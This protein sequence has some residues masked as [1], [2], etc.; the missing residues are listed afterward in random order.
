MQPRL[1]QGRPDPRGT[2]PRGP[3]PT[4]F[5][6]LLLLLGLTACGKPSGE[7]PFSQ[8]MHSGKNYYDQGQITNAIVRFER[9]V[10][11]E[12]AQPDA[13]LNLANAYLL[14][15]QP[16]RALASAEQALSFDRNLAAGY[17]VAGCAHLRLRQFE[18]AVKAFFSA[19]DL[20]ANVAA[21]HYQLGV[22][23]VELGQVE[24][25]AASFEEAIRLEP[26]HPVAHYALGQALIRAGRQ[27]E[28]LEAIQRHQ[29]IRAKNPNAPP[30]TT[31]THERCVYTQARAPQKPARPDPKG[32][33][34][35]FTEAT[36][37]VFGDTAA[38]YRAP[39]A[40]LDF[41]RND[42]NGLFVA[43]GTH[44]FR[45]LA[46]RDGRFTPQGEP[47]ARQADTAF[48]AALTGDLNNDRYEDVLVLGDTA[49]HAFRFAT[50]GAARDLTRA[51]GLTGLVARAGAF[52]DLDFT[53]KLDLIALRPDG[54]G[55]RVLRNLGSM[56]FIDITATSG[57]PAQ[58]TGA[59]QLAVD[60][61]N[62]DDLL[63]VF[64]SRTGAPPLYL[65]K[66]RGGPLVPTNLPAGTLEGS[67]LA[68][69]DVNG[70]SRTDLFVGADTHVDLLLGGIDRF[71][72]LPLAQPGLDRLR[73]FDYDNDGWLDLLATGTGLQLWRN[74]GDGRFEN[75]TQTT[76]LAALANTPIDDVAL[77]DFDG[78]GDTDLV[79]SLAGPT[80]TGLRYYRNDG[81]NTHRQLKLRLI[82]N[83]SNASGLGIRLEVAS[84]NFRVH[85][86][87]QSL[88]IEIGV[89]PRDHLE[90]LTARWFDLPYHIVD[91]PV[92]PKQ[93]LEV[94]EPILPTGSCPYL[95]AWD[96]QRFRF[97]TDLLGSAPVGLRVAD[98]VFAAADP[99]EFVA[100]GD[101]TTFAPRDGRYVLQITEE[102]R[103]V[104]YLDEAKLVVVD[105]PPDT[106]VHTTDKF[107]PGP[108]FPRGELWTLEN[109]VP[110]RHATRLDGSDC[111]ELLQ[112]I[113]DR[114][115]SPFALRIPQLRGLAEPHG[116][117]LDFGPLPADRPLVLALTGWLRFGGGMA[118]VAASHDPDLPFPFPQLEVETTPDHWQPVDVVAGAPSGKTKTI[119]IDLA[120]H[121]P[122]QSLRLRLTTAF[123]IHWDRIAL[124]HRRPPTDTRL[125]WLAPD[126]ADLH[127]RGFSEF[128]DL[129]WTFPL[130]PVYDQVYQ[131]AP[132]TI[133]PVGW[134]TRYGPVDPL[135]AAEDNAVALL[136][137]GDELTLEFAA[138]R[139]PA[140]P[141]GTHRSFFLYT[142]GWD[143]DADFHVQL[144]WCVDPW[145]WHGMDD[146]RYG[147]E[148]R[149]AFASDELMRRYTTRW[150]PQYTLRR[151][152]IQ[153]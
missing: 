84:G 49:S 71:H 20:D 6:A 109:R 72:R 74:V 45:V 61:W 148:T 62:N 92:D 121:L 112:A 29:A 105:H 115:V 43:E 107:R 31:A 127:W 54:A 151:P 101:A 153:R 79:L 136:N 140:P 53:G 8:A 37:S 34:V 19:R 87:V 152:A 132:W 80:E 141:P 35:R 59:R 7:D 83:R 75:V 122:A 27:E 135:V 85:R 44:G 111:T 126:I 28:G 131:T 76:G 11:L 150:V 94:P 1:P 67:V 100:L 113:D 70:D 55:L 51:S 5:T 91:L 15:D 10:E 52:V 50:N 25:A 81:G 129:D 14:V 2:R 89:G 38:H 102:L 39:L 97:V 147:L 18:E 99:R 24:D 145:P 116:V 32:I 103:E 60:D 65:Q 48:F 30:A 86:T 98:T 13:L 56:Y 47:L 68:L 77:A 64:V 63:D 144:G 66:Q 36:S 4:S 133:T 58:I 137:G 114:R 26:E 42:Q 73:L 120:G 118:N 123:E 9:A 130:T 69:G 128:A 90:A 88:P 149:P 95:Y 41:N 57:V 106:E 23:Q 22:G 117:V 12:P 125:T 119:L 146:Q 143:K 82:G 3:G 46:N 139:L 138:S 93:A 21:T 142:V 110:L 108:P 33:T 104:L 40:V 124:F 96:G 78:D 134:C 16:E 17:Y